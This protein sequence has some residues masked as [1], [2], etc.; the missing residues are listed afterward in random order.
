M[1]KRVQSWW[2]TLSMKPRTLWMPIARSCL[3]VRLAGSQSE[4]PASR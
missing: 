4:A 3:A 1:L 2:V